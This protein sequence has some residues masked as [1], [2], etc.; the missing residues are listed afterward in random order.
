MKI[1]TQLF[2]CVP[3][4]LHISY[5]LFIEPYSD[6]IIDRLDNVLRPAQ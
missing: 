6:E 1:I 2:L 4:L 5:I 3:F